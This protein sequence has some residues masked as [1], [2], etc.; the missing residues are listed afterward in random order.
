LASKSAQANYSLILRISAAVLSKIQHQWGENNHSAIIQES[1][2]LCFRGELESFLKISIPKTSALSQF[3]A[4][5]SI[6]IETTIVPNPL[7]TKR[8][9][10]S[11][12]FVVV[13]AVLTGLEESR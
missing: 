5:V 7:L 2:S 1:I 3:D 9:N 10:S 12:T 8:N 11:L 6:L 4:N 13:P